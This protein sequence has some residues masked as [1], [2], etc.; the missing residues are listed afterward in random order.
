MLEPSVGESLPEEGLSASA[1]VLPLPTGL[2]LFSVKAAAPLA[3]RSTGQLSLPA[4]HV[5]LGP[6]VRS[7]QV[8]FMSGPGNGG[9]WLFAHGDVLIVKVNGSGATL[10]LTSVRSSVGEVLSIEVERLEARTQAAAS[11]PTQGANI[12]DK[13]PRAPSQAADVQAPAAQTPKSADPVDEALTLPLQIKTHI[14]AR[15]DMSFADAP[16][17]GRVAPGL[18]IESFSVQPLKHLG[19]QHIEY[20]AL[21]GTGFETPWLSDDQICGTKG[22]SVPLVGFAVRLKPGSEASSYDC[23]Y[24]G[25]YRSSVVVGPLRNGAPCR[26]TVANDPLEGIQI[27]IVKRPSAPAANAGGTVKTEPQRPG[28]KAPS[29]G[30]YRDAAAESVDGEKSSASATKSAKRVKADAPSG[31]DRST[32]SAHRAPTRLS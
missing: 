20:K 2:Y 11:V 21:T 23:E 1:Q 5:G 10:I 17:A 16:W 18:W 7:D 13:L 30:R 8:E 6:G 19:A 9:T 26:S 32:R 12:S 14:R 31:T 25:Y 29:F 28:I 27:R 3:E 4:M 15:G 22:M 24:S